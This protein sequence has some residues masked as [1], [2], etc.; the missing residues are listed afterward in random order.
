VGE[1]EI[2]IIHVCVIV[3]RVLLLL[4]NEFL[5]EMCVM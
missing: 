5:S 2:I 1:I 3:L 4:I